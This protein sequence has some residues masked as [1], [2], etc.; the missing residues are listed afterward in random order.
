MGLRE[1]DKRRVLAAQKQESD[2]RLLAK[3]NELLDLIDALPESLDSAIRR[4]FPAAECV[5]TRESASGFGYTSL[6]NGRPV[7]KIEHERVCKS[8][9]NQLLQ[10]VHWCKKYGVQMKQ[11]LADAELRV[12]ARFG[13]GIC[14][15][16]FSPLFWLAI[17]DELG[18][19]NDIKSLLRIV[20]ESNVKTL[21]ISPVREIIPSA[22]IALGI[23][24]E[25][26][27]VSKTKQPD[28]AASLEWSIFRPPGDWYG[29]FAMSGQ[30]WRT[31]LK[32][33]WIPEGMA[34]RDPSTPK[35]GKVQF[36]KSLLI[37]RGLTEPD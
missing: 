6:I 9:L 4:L 20:S 8:V 14:E 11:I 1:L 30:R 13:K 26:P 22:L 19:G 29:I 12:V 23:E 34:R 3:K 27:A 24:T 21:I 32:T 7:Q 33:E 36:R 10:I 16:K 28:N 37:D 35:R 31:A 15:S 5:D 25:T 2:K 17:L 18:S